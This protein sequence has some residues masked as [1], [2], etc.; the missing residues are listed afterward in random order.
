MQNCLMRSKAKESQ[1]L[2]FA[3]CSE[4]WLIEEVLDWVIE[5]K[6]DEKKK[7]LTMQHDY[8]RIFWLQDEN[9]RFRGKKTNNA[10]SVIQQCFGLVISWKVAEW[11]NPVDGSKKNAWKWRNQNLPLG[12]KKLKKVSQMYILIQVE[13][14]GSHYLNPMLLN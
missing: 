13:L 3:R 6:W 7:L 10:N 1:S 5:T 4:F 9:F 12:K 14:V 2:L 8:S 11:W